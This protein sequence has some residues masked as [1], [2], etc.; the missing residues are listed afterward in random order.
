[1]QCD[2]ID[3]SKLAKFNDG[4]KYLLTAIDVFTKYA[5]VV[6]LKS[7]NFESM[8]KAFKKLFKQC[9]VHISKIQT[10]FEGEFYNKLVKNYFKQLNIHHYSSYSEHKASVVER[11]NRT[12]KSRLFRIFIHTNSYRYVDTL[13][14]VVKKMQASIALLA[15]SPIKLYPN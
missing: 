12:L 11:F 5:G 13:K 15:M 4:I 9:N 10:D 3:M 2:L 1:M 6:P 14:S 8:L 7:K